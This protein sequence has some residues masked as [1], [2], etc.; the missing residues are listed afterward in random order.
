MEKP[1]KLWKGQSLKHLRKAGLPSTFT[2]VLQ[3]FTSV[4][5]TSDVFRKPWAIW[6][7]K[8]ENLTGSI[9]TIPEKLQDFYKCSSVPSPTV[10]HMPL[11]KASLQYL[12]KRIDIIPIVLVENWGTVFLR[13]S[14][15]KV[16][17][18]LL[19]VLD[20]NCLSLNRQG[21]CKPAENLIQPSLLCASVSS[22]LISC[23]NTQYYCKVWLGWHLF[24]HKGKDKTSGKEK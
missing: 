3:S 24:Y 22:H 19:Y 18:H 23:S 10:L 21:D 7:S 16:V 15:I 17:L 20:W 2:A 1:F 13:M 12:L 9:Y 8:G 11:M 14:F 5:W 4:L 6:T